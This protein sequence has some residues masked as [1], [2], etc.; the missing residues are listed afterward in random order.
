LQLPYSGHIVPAEPPFCPHPVVAPQWVVSM[1]GSTHVPPQS[2]IGGVQVATHAPFE[3]DAPVAQACPAEPT[4]ETP[5]PG[6]APQFVDEELG[7]MQPDPHSIMPD[8]HRQ[9]PSKHA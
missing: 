6:V 9:V 4:L 7:S 8:V 1:V 3:H 2:T 5:Q